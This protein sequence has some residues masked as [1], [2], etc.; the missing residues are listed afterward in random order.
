MVRD[1]DEARRSLI[2][3]DVKVGEIQE[4]R[5]GVKYAA[6][7]DPEGNSWTLQEM[8]HGDPGNGPA[9]SVA[10]APT[11]PHQRRACVCVRFVGRRAAGGPGEADLMLRRAG[12][13]FGRATLRSA[14]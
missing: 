3:K 9:R 6:F 8:P 4:Q 5:E 10:H 2:A 12:A 1:I 13:D 11:G 7:S 14:P